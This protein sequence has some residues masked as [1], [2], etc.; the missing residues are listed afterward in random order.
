MT[1][2]IAPIV[3]QDRVR[4][5]AESALPGAPIVPDPPHRHPMYAARSSLARGLNAAAAVIA[6]KAEPVA[7]RA[8]QAC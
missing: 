6:P 5:L 2:P 1:M 4:A 3:T 8:P 7:G